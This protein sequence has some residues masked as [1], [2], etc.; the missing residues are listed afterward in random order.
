MHR[1]A[2][3][4]SSDMKFV[5]FVPSREFIAQ[6]YMDLKESLFDANGD[7]FKPET[8]TFDAFCWGVG[9]VRSRTHPPLENDQA[10][11]VPMADLVRCC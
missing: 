8:F 1:I 4:N 2:V 5:H 9:S 6:R 11:L 3:L 10:A 7:I